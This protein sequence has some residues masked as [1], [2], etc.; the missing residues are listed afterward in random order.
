MD[1][2]KWISRITE[3]CEKYGSVRMVRYIP[4]ELTPIGEETVKLFSEIVEI[5]DETLNVDNE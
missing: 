5:Y 3:V 2:A 4:R 1:D